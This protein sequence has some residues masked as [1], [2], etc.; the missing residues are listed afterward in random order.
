LALLQGNKDAFLALQQE[1][2]V[3]HEGRCPHTH[4]K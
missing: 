3:L 1:H 4:R 2:R